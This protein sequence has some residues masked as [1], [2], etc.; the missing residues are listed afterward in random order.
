M[1][2]LS[3][4]SS[5]VL[6]RLKEITF[7]R[8]WQKSF[9]N[10]DKDKRRLLIATPATCDQPVIHLQRVM[11]SRDL[12]VTANGAISAVIGSFYC[13]LFPETI[14]QCAVKDVCSDSVRSSVP[15]IMNISPG[16]TL[17]VSAITYKV[18]SQIISS[19]SLA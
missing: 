2:H 12:S 14:T 15:H 7:S 4:L 13:F 5:F 16:N 6:H 1:F 17:S 3:E 9:A 18:P 19:R 11:K 10:R 8:E